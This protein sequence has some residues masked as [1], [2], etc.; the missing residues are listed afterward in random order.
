VKRPL[1]EL[2]FGKE[3]KNWKKREEKIPPDTVYR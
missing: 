3:R 1:K 2:K